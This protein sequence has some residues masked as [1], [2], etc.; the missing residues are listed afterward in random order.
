MISDL[1]ISSKISGNINTHNPAI[2]KNDLSIMPY[3]FSRVMNTKPLHLYFEVYNLKLNEENKANYE[4]SYI[5]K[6]IRAERNFWQK[7][8]GGIPRLFSNQDKNIISTTV[9]REGDSATAFEYISFDLR[10]LARGLT[11]LRVKVTD[12]NN[13]QSTENAIEFTLVK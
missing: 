3:P 12:T 2:V 8:V 6:T 7:T 1:Q 5:L 11:E 9:Q 4:V 10:N 13:N